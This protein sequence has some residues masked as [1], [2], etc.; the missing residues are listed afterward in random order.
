[1]DLIDE[2]NKI[3]EQLTKLNEKHLK[4]ERKMN[5]LIIKINKMT[6]IASYSSNSSIDDDIKYP[7]DSDY[8]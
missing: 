8:D 3:K 5:S 1:M 7:G 6:H 2:V 4:I